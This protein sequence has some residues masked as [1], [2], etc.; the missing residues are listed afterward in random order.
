MKVYASSKIE[1]VRNSAGLQPAIAGENVIHYSAMPWIDF[2]AVSHARAFSFPDSCPKISLG[3]MTENNGRRTMPMS[4]HVHHA[5][6]DGLNVAQYID[7]F[8][9]LMNDPLL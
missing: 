7:A 8:Q 4:V 1:R 5:L 9:Q 3:K 2:T 6:A